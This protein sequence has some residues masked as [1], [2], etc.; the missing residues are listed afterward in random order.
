MAYLDSAYTNGVIAVREKYLLKEKLLRFCA[1]TAE[2]SFRALLDSG[3]GG[4][5][6]TT[7]NVYEYEKLL[8]A[9]EKSLNSFIREY[10]PSYTEKAFLLSSRDFHNAKALVKAHFLG[11]SPEKMLTEQGLVDVNTL[12]ECVQKGDFSALAHT[13]YLQKA[14]QDAT[15]SL[16]EN[17]SG[18]KI[19]EIFEKNLYTHLYVLVKNKRGLKKILVRKVDM[20]NILIAFRANGNEDNQ[21][22]YLPFG[23][24]TATDL[25][26]LS[27]NE[28][29]QAYFSKTPYAEF[30]KTCIL[31]KEKNLPFTQA[32]KMLDGFELDWYA[33]HKYELKKHEPFLYYAY[34]RK[35]ENANVRIVFACLLAGLNEQEIIKRLRAI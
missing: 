21:E 35:T 34:R 12:S 30:V 29:A 31:A 24:L 22:K 18:A 6:E 5:A 9:D 4:G 14:C 11:E 8:S 33:Q 20:T 23:S 16:T 17:A 26:K 3:F 19:G 15:L 27:D 10:A 2:E 13:P 1:L 25:Q 28:Q 32:E 7:V